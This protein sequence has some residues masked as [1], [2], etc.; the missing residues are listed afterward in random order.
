[1]VVVIRIKMAIILGAIPLKSLWAVLL[2]SLEVSL[3]SV[4]WPLARGLVSLSEMWV[5]MTVVIHIVGS[6]VRSLMV[7]VNWSSSRI[8]P[9]I[10]IRSIRDR[11]HPLVIF[12][13]SSHSWLIPSTILCVVHPSLS[14]RIISPIGILI[15]HSRESIL[16][17][18]HSG[19]GSFIS[20]SMCV[21]PI[22]V[23][24]SSITPLDLGSVSIT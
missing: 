17:A 22:S 18:S 16:V 1:M 13:V 9:D 20:I 14:P 10:R 23:V 21:I 5:V 19:I 8:A 2:P 6:I 11:V 15:S 24:V 7:T 12:V 4:K 3:R